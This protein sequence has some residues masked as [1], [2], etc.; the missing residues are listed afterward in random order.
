M[1]KKAALGVAMAVV[2][3]FLALPLFAK[4]IYPDDRIFTQGDSEKTKSPYF[5]VQGDA[6]VESFPLLSTKADVVVSGM[7]AEVVL[8]Q[9]YKN[10]GKKAIEAVYV[11]P[12]G[13]RSAIHA[14]RMKIGSRIID[15][16]I[17]ETEA[18]KKIYEQAKNNGQTASLLTQERPNVFQMK[19]AN[20][21]PGDLIEVY[22]NYAEILVPENRVYEFVFPTVV[23][24]RFT[25][26]ST[27]ASNSGFTAQPYTTEGKKSAY[28]FDIN[29]RI[30][31]TMP[32]SKV[33]SDS[34]RISVQ[35][36]NSKTAAISLSGS[37][38]NSGNKDFIIDYTYEGGKIQ[39]GAVLYK[40]EN[41]NFFLMMV[42]PPATTNKAAIPAREY[43]FI[44]DVS[45]SMNGFPLDT[46]KKVV[47]KVLEG[48]DSK[49]Y[50]NVVYF[51][52]GS[53]TLFEKPFPA[54]ESNKKRAIAALD[55][56]NGGGG[57]MLLEALRT[58]IK[59]PK[60]EGM[61]R[62]VVIAT[63]GY[64]DVEKE[65]FD[66]IRD[67]MSNANFFAFGIG[68]SVNRFLIEGMARAGKG[69]PF[70][71]TDPSQADSAAK[72]FSDYVNNPLL[73][74]IKVRFDGF[75][76]YDV[77]PESQ[78][79][80]FAKRPLV[81]TG[82]YKN[83]SGRIHIQGMTGE[84]KYE[85]TINISSADADRDNAAVMYIWAREKVAQLDD[86]SK[87][88]VDVKKRVTELGLKYHLMTAYTS[89]VAV[90]KVKRNNGELV[91][92]KQPLPLPEGVSNLAVEEN[93]PASPALY[94]AGALGYGGSGVMA[95]AARMAP[96]AS[97]SMDAAEASVQ[98]P[99]A[100]GTGKKDKEEVKQQ[101]EQAAGELV[102]SDIKTDTTLTPDQIEKAVFGAIKAEL[103]NYM[104]ANNLT[105][106]EVTLSVKNGTVTAITGDK[107]L[108]AI[109][110]KVGFA[111]G[112]G[113]V[114]IVFER[115]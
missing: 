43:M 108:K 59:L 11:F 81:I 90:D 109:M 3:L 67:N 79:D 62:T 40:G 13:T 85:E 36:I 97:L 1:K 87:V 102:I 8:T 110:A 83:A 111:S 96:Q 86:Y 21:M 58:A 80:L 82:K 84:D 77:E 91:T 49:D 72:K 24:P 42:E 60:K 31:G 63:D 65:S 68:T 19:V 78:P 26:E 99:K 18:A 75:D 93:V 5:Q 115:M 30:N 14:M 61:S 57:T 41:E 20:I 25:G 27:P 2:L 28:T 94:N 105:S 95:K 29:V 56:Y 15:A 37:E 64:V 98:E 46:S 9:T 34:H 35:N 7:A 44:V 47:K 106:L 32:I 76:A 48:M 107:T 53:D 55:S 4:A 89:F 88:G 70:I 22:V 113:K 33:W 69:A 74:D 71:V 17:N 39:T 51:A 16:E 12:L 23:G 73:T 52:G 103:L 45:G 101:A 112:N 54:T 114:T 6:T 38:A 92:V 104:A 100:F 10:D 66:L 50:F